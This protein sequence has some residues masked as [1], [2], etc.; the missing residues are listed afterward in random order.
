M[1]NV[2]PSVTAVGDAIDEGGTA[3]VSA[4]FVDP[5][6]LDTHTATIDWDDGT[7]PVAVTVAQLA[8]GVDHVYGDNGVYSVLI[9]VTDDDGG[10]GDDIATVTVGNLDPVLALDLSGE[11]MFPGGA[12]QVVEAGEA[13]PQSADG[14]DPGSDD[15]RFTWSGGDINTYFNDGVGPD[16]FPSPLGTFPFMASDGSDALYAMPGVQVLT[17]TLTDDDGGSDASSSNV[18]VT[19]TADKTE[20]SGWWKHQYSGKG[21]PHIEPATAAA[22]GEIVSAVS[23]VFSEDTSA[24]SSAEIHAILSPTGNDPR[25]RATAELMVAWLQFA[26]GAVSWDATVPL[27][28]G[29]SMPF[30]DLMFAAEEVILDPTA[31]KAELQEIERLL[32]RVRH[33]S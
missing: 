7:A 24:A 3:T 15:L 17:L 31:T 18:V 20:G 32:A 8:L 19:G 9:T 10:A 29:A 30:L 26:S 5:G 4:T 25:G 33:A 16:P 2:A 12:Y 14:S 28:G 6:I 22:Y 27:A 11:V 13:L 1:L 23:S 21:T